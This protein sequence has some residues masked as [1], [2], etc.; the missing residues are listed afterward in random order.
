MSA[1]AG[2]A[3]ANKKALLSLPRATAIRQVQQD[4]KEGAATQKLLYSIEEGAWLLSLG[5]T[6][7]WSLIK[8]NRLH[9]VRINGRT[10]LPHSELEAFAIRLQEGA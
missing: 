7:V 8:E 5:R 10:L 9:A 1:M 3:P 4:P 2:K 6:T